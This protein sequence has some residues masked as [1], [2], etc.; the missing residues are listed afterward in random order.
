LTVDIKVKENVC[1]FDIE[2]LIL[3]CFIYYKFFFVKKYLVFSTLLEIQVYSQLNYDEN[4]I[5]VL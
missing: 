4:K 1:C 3:S 5:Q 2:F